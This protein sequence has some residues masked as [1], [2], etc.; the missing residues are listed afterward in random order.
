MARAGVSWVEGDDIAIEDG[1]CIA[2]NG[3]TTGVVGVIQFEGDARNFE[4]VQSSQ[5]PIYIN[6]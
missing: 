1:L 2:W 3:D 4:P 6:P 5:G